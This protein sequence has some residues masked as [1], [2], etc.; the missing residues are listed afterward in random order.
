MYYSVLVGG[1]SFHGQ[2]SLTYSHDQQ[3]LPGQVVR[4]QLRSRPTLGLITGTVAKPTFKIKPVDEVLPVHLNPPQLQLLQWLRSYYPAPLG[5]IVDLFLPSFIDKINLSKTTLPKAP[6]PPFLPELTSEQVAAMKQL[7]AGGAQ[8]FLLHGDTG[9]GKTRVYIEASRQALQLGKSVLVLTPEIGLTA[10]LA[11]Q[12]MAVFGEQQVLV[13]HSGLTPKKRRIAWEQL[14]NATEPMV[15]IGPRSALFSPLSQLGLVIMDEAHDGAYKQGQQP[16]YQASRVAAQLARFHNCQFIIGTATPLVA[17]YFTFTSKHLPIIRMKRPAVGEA[18]A[19][20]KDIIDLKDFG[21]FTR[22]NWLSNQLVAALE[23]ALAKQEQGLLFL[24]RRGSARLVLCNHCGWQ[25]LCPRCDIALTYHADKHRMLCHSCGY[26]QTVPTLC[27]E[28]SHSDLIFTVAGTK[29][30]EVELARLFPEARIMRFD[31]DTASDQSLDKQ[32]KAIAAGEVDFVI[33]TQAIVKGFDLPKLSVVGIVQADSGLQI[34]DYSA[35]ERTYQLI[36]QV[37]GR[38][39]R[40][41]RAG[42][43][44]LQTHHPDT[45]LLE[46][47]INKDYESF[48]KNELAHRLAFGFPPAAYLLKVSSKR[49]SQSSAKQ[50]LDK[51]ITQIA[52]QSGLHIIG[53]APCYPEKL[54]NS[55][56]WQC[57]VKAKDRN[58]LTALVQTTTANL[59]FDIDPNDLL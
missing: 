40:G 30:I 36:S 54:G 53:P 4:L 49:A 55:Y 23:T 10:P 16:Y 35:T 14:Y 43:L 20:N 11:E 46:Q 7:D 3:L 51:F 25:A 50:A 33:G 44:F 57:L 22:S 47:A 59:T 2:D 12:F 42:N 28:C 32:Y 29:T 17:D 1:K 9:T 18:H 26:Y 52:G 15:V 24:N 31:K 21:S 6:K 58:L 45:L 41:H 19:I 48:Y 38:I 37:A 13:L 27:P 56:R 39:G 8:S 5:S 34:A